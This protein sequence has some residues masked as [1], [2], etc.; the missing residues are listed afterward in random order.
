MSFDGHIQ[1]VAVA[2]EGE[3][4][5][6]EREPWFGMVTAIHGSPDDDNAMYDIIWLER[7]PINRKYYQL[8]ET[9]PVTQI[10]ADTIIMFGLEVAIHLIRQSKARVYRIQTPLNLIKKVWNASPT[11]K[12]RVFEESVTSI[13]NQ[14]T[15]V[16]F[17]E[18]MS[19]NYINTDNWISSIEMAKCIV[20]HARR[21]KL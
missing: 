14:G 3:Q 1:W 6:M 8:C 17:H 11:N 7:S 10:S 9:Q 18:G 12:Q 15:H 19:Y 20:S 13:P 4:G 2:G 16:V 21:L 5:Q